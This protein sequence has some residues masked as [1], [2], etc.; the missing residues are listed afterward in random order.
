MPSTR[1]SASLAK[2]PKPTHVPPRFLNL[3]LSALLVIA[4]LFWLPSVSP[5]TLYPQT[6]QLAPSVLASDLFNYRHPLTPVVK[7]NISPHLSTSSYILLD[8]DT[9]TVLL[10]QNPHLRIYPASLTKLATA[11]T[12]LNLYPLDE[13]VTIPH[14]YKDGKV[15]ELQPGEKIT[16][17]S[18][19]TALLVHSANDA[20]YNLALHHS[21]GLTGFINEMN[22]LMTRYSLTDT[23]FANYDGIH[24]PNHYSTVYDL[25]QLARLSIKHPI[26]TDVVKSTNLTVT[27]TDG[28]IAHPLVT[29]NELLGIVPEI[30][31]L[32]TGWTPEAG[33][34]FIGLID[35]NGHRLISVVVQSQDRFADTT[36]LVTWAKENVT[37]QPYSLTSSTYR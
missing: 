21:S 36:S 25:S 3:L 32:K 1:R 11:L 2:R 7:S 22:L 37:W 10:S 24:L 27:N 18:L 28:T 6:N 17:R 33:G 15:M 19:V 5:F 31:G 13:I 29:T 12:A 26:I 30:K 8:H 34:C 16:V 35:L 4:N 20:A 14:E 23:N 9:N